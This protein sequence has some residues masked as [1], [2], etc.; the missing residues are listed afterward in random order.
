MFLTAFKVADF[1]FMAWGQLFASLLAACAVV[2][3]RTFAFTTSNVV[4]SAADR[5]YTGKKDS[6]VTGHRR[7]RAYKSRL[8]RT[9]NSATRFDMLWLN[10]WWQGYVDGRA[11]CG[12]SIGASMAERTSRC[13]LA[14]SSRA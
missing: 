1:A 7:I 5:P 14:R 6:G 13:P 10:A 11:S 8:F 9:F 2:A 12:D 3:R 4:K